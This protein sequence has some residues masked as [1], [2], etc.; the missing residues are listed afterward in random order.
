MASNLPPCI[1]IIPARYGSR[2]FPGK[3]LAQI[4]GRPMF[5][6]VYHR[7]SQCPQLDRVLLATD[8]ERIRQLAEALNV[9]VVMTSAD[10]PSGSDRILEA[11][12]TIG[13]SEACVIVNIQ[14]DEPALAPAMISQLLGPF[15]QPSMQVTTLARRINMQIAD[16]PN[17]VKVVFAHDGRALYFSRALIPGR[18]GRATDSIYYGHIGLYA[19]R[20]HVLEQ[21][22]QWGPSRLERTE[23]LEQLR[24]LE[25]GIPIQVVITEHASLGVDVPEDLEAVIKIL[26]DGP[27]EK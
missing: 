6:H 4:L 18:S 9:P 22:V 5:W 16:N 23:K 7:A 25:N 2:R 1:G 20:K 24:L 10:H 13:A 12:R 15:A 21:F 3:P 27:V 8:D 19:Y 11:A 26:S 14:G 17:V